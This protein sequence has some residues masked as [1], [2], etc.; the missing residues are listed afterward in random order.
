MPLQQLSRVL[1]LQAV[2][3]ELPPQKALQVPGLKSVVCVQP[4]LG[5]LVGHDPGWPAPIPVS[6]FSPGSTMPLPHTAGQSLSLLALQP[7][8]QQ[9]SAVKEQVAATCVQWAWQPVP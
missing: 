7:D 3:V 6:Q 2:G 5:Q 8:G 9:L 1:R 4:E